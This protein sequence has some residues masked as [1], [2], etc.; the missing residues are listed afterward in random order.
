MREYLA[1]S[2][3]VSQ[4]ARPPSGPRA[5]PLGAER[6]LSSAAVENAL[7]PLSSSRRIDIMMLLAKDDESLATLSKAL[8]MKKGHL[9]FHLNVLSDAGYIAY[10]R[11]SR[12]YALTNKGGRALEGIARLMERIEA[13]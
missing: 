1:V 10:D 11:K 2:E 4:Q 13:A 9:Q 5:S 12:L 3:R 8:D 7:A 6:P